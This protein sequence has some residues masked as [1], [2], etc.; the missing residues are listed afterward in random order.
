VL[1]RDLKPANVM[2]DGRGSVRITDFGLAA[3]ADQFRKEAGQGTRAGT[4]AYMSPEQLAGKPATIRSDVYSLGLVL[5][6]MFTGKRAFKGGSFHD[7]QKLH[8]SEHPTPPSDIIHDI[9]PIVERVILRCLEKDPKDRPA[10]AMAV[11]AGLPGGDPLREIL[12]AGETPSPEV[13]AAAGEAHRGLSPRL[14]TF[15][16]V[17]GLLC[18]IIVGILAP[19]TFVVQQAIRENPPVVLAHQA[20]EILT[21]LGY[22]EK[23]EDSASG[24][25]VNSAYYLHVQSEPA[26]ADRIHLLARP[27]LGLISFW[28][29]ESPEALIP[30]HP[31]T[32]VAIDDPP[33]MLPGMVRVSLDPLGRLIGLEAQASADTVTPTTQPQTH[34]D[35]SPLLKASG[36]DAGHFRE[37]APSRIPSVFTDQRAAWEGSFDDAREERVH[38]EAGM[39]R[40]KPAYFAI[41][42]GWKEEL[43][44][45]Q[46]AT[47]QSL[48]N[49]NLVVQTLVNIGLLL[50]GSYLAYKNHRSGR[51]DRI[52][53]TRL[54]VAF[55]IL[56]IIAWLFRTHHVANFVME[57]H[58]FSHAMG[59]VMYT[60]GLVWIFYLALEPYV[61][62]I[63]PETVISWNRLLAGRWIDPIVGRDVLIG[64]VAGIFTTML[65]T[66]G[67]LVPVWIG[68]PAPMPSINSALQML[69]SATNFS[70][71]FSGTISAMYIGLLLLLFVV[72]MRMGFER[73]WLVA[74]GFVSIFVGASA[75]W[76]SHDYISWIVQAITAVIFLGVIIR[77]GLVAIIFCSL[78]RML[79][80]D[81]PVTFDFTA[82][83]KV[84]AACG[85]AATLLIL[86]VST[87]AALG[88]KPLV[89]L[90]IAE[91]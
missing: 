79:L 69:E 72:V 48:G 8:S 87:Y 86:V 76:A 18:L 21:T 38:V 34:P 19:R 6:E 74:F 90:R 29:R 24:Y 22:S 33:A 43:L 42:G 40:G 47:E 49:V 26:S 45:Q 75:Q 51:G 70:T 59:T 7:Y 58:L 16:L 41:R 46:Q 37:V 4:P 85:I 55:L 12:A 11:S 13:V 73:R 30:W 50:V 66:L 63:W 83:Y 5:Y 65:A 28:Y 71:L 77:H 10:S 82:W 53:A 57:F 61:R 67:R 32:A 52:G 84:S 62:R 36:M 68:L 2:I 31:D 44:S 9:D 64:A 20:K 39:L 89:T 15:F 80:T 78:T 14:A 91:R 17:A 54:A 27:R 25:A 35:W 56:G 88:G 3:P 81:F 60:V 23:P 1:H